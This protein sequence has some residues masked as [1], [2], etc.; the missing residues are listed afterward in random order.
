MIGDR[1]RRAA[2][3]TVVL[4][5]LVALAYGRAPRGAFVFDDHELVVENP[6]VRESPGRPG[7]LFGRDG[8]AAGFAYRPVRVLSYQVDH[9]LGGGLDPRVF[10]LSNLLWHLATSVALFLLARSMIGSDEAALV[11]AAIF[12]VHPAGSEAV[13]YVSGRRDLLC[14]FFGLLALGAAWRLLSARASGTGHQRGAVVVALACGLLALG[15]K[16]TAIVLAPIAWLMTFVRPPDPAPRATSRARVGALVAG[17]GALAVAA[18][19]YRERIGPIVARAGSSP[20]ARQPALT[21]R[22]LGRYL[23]LAAFPDDLRADYRSG[24][25]E[26]PREA[27]EPR[28]IAAGFA[29]SGV[30]VLGVALLRRGAVAGLGLLWFL[31]ALLPVAQVVPYSEVVAEHNAY[32]PLAGLALAAGDGYARVRRASGPRWRAAAALA[33]ALLVAGFAFRTHR[34][35]DDWH[36]EESLWR[37][38]LEVAPDSRRALHNLG[39]TLA[40]QGRLQAAVAPLERAH[41][42]DPAD[43]DVRRTLA[44]V[45][46]DVGEGARAVETAR[47]LTVEPGDGESWNVLGW[48]Q[49]ASGDSTSARASFAR[50]RALGAVREA[51]LGLRAAAARVGGAGP[52]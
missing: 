39:A 21:L 33:V 15:S 8:E 4:A 51:D 42:A 26:L 36:D 16:E 2:L 3:A 45:L 25:F 10:H 31:V 12:A 1:T 19:L 43:V 22:V 47:P 50:A 49:L 46:T 40:A 30:A 44:R 5:A 24:A 23:R 11:A 28:T 6:L 37:A 35:V 27:F 14:G 48:A 9:L 18:A 29:V 7:A 20:I 41:R 17:A 38:T 32:L 13:A 34:R 52:P